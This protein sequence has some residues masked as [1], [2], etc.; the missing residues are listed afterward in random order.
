MQTVTQVTPMPLSGRQQGTGLFWRRGLNAPFLHAG[1][2]HGG[3]EGFEAMY[4]LA[5][6]TWILKSLLRMNIRV[7]TERKHGT[8]S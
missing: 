6:R 5:N 3:V 7:G 8:R 2:N 4:L 1:D